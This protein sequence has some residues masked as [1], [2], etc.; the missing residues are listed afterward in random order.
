VLAQCEALNPEAVSLEWKRAEQAYKRLKEKIETTERDEHGLAVEL[1]T[2]GQR[3]LAEDLE[4]KQSERD[5]ARSKLARIEADAEAWK[6]LLCTLREAEREAKEIF[7]GPVHKRLLP[8]LRILLPDAELR[9]SE[10]DMEIVLIR[11]NGVDEPFASLSIG[12]REQVAV[13]ARLAL[14]DLLRE[15]AGRSC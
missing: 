13:I 2:L 11:R 8:Y 3:G 4:K 9:L 5:M 14:A 6:L 10:D 12:A 15:K 7:L 1:R